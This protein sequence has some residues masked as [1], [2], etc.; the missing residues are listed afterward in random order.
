M[1]MRGI[2]G[3]AIL[4]ALLGSAPAAADTSN[5][6]EDRSG[7]VESDERRIATEYLSNEYGLNEEQAAQHLAEQ[8]AFNELYTDLKSDYREDTL[9]AYI[10]PPS[11][12][13]P[14]HIRSSDPG[15]AET[16]EA[17]TAETGISVELERAPAIGAGIT[18]QATENLDQI[19]SVSED[20][21]QGVYVDLATGEVVIGVYVEEGVASERQLQEAT[22]FQGVPELDGTEVRVVVH[23]EPSTD[24]EAYGGAAMASCTTG[25]TAQSTAGTVG[26][27]SAAHG[28]CGQ[29][30]TVYSGT[31]QSTIAGQSTL[32]STTY[33][34]NADISYHS[35]PSS[36]TVYGSYW[37]ESSTSTTAN[38]ATVTVAQ[39]A[40]ICGRGMTTGVRC[41]VASPNY[42]PTYEG[43]CPSG[44]C[45]ASFIMI[46][47]APQAG[48]DSGGPWWFGPGEVVGIHKGGSSTWS[49]A[50]A[51]QYVPSGTSLQ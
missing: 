44:S 38:V 16:V 25:F 6:E 42:Q 26:F 40:N 30:Q 12:G 45:N 49:V 47:G 37:G 28:A 36:V 22:E 9:D 32:Q 39:G 4:G 31:T 10:L 15:V 1:K 5:G 29:G 23:D 14:L 51:I 24:A 41:G 27:W 21:I 7:V 19:T 18:E 34:D 48:G 13:P 3:L 20:E 33:N 43:A 2:T 8:G 46:D 35:M 17:F 50:S 11:A